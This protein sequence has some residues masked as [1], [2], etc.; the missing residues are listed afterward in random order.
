[1][2]ADT[3]RLDKGHAP[4]AETTLR[5]RPGRSAG[6]SGEAAPQTARIPRSRGRS[7]ASRGISNSPATRGL[8]ISGGRRRACFNGDDVALKERSSTPWCKYRCIR[9][10]RHPA[11]AGAGPFPSAVKYCRCSPSSRLA[12]ARRGVVYDGSRCDAGLAPRAA[13]R[14]SG[15]SV[16]R[17]DGGAF[18]CSS[19]GER[20]GFI[21]DGPLDLDDPG[22]VTHDAARP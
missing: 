21:R 3:T 1:M 9:P 16:P 22:E 4:C 19:P 5:V 7:F 14:P 10:A 17:P 13:K 8:D 18:F 6:L 2:V 11:K 12:L 20:Y 15:F